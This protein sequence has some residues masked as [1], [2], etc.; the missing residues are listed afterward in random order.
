VA[1][2][3]GPFDFRRARRI[4]DG[5]ALPDPQLALARGYDHNFVLEPGPGPQASLADPVS[6]RRMEIFTDAPGL[7]FYSGNYLDGSLGGKGRDF[8]RYAGLCLEP[9][10]FPDAP[11]QPHFPD[12]ICR[13]GTPY[14]A[15]TRY[16]I[17]K[18]RPTWN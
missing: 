11:N 12:A 9:Q 17:D 1:V 18:W 13:P 16:V 7:Q 5:L 3:G 15:T 8:T 6:G 2:A 10:H 14:S 4:G